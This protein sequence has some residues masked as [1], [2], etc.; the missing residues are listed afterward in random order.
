[1]NKK[2][3][4]PDWGPDWDFPPPGDIL[5]TDDIPLPL[6]EDGVIRV[7]VW[8]IGPDGQNL[9]KE[10][11]HLSKQILMHPHYANGLTGSIHVYVTSP[12]SNE[13]TTPDDA[14]NA[15]KPPVGQ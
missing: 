5:E 3:L 10:Q 2:I 1:M 11:S 4:P 8:F 14:E 7:E 6:A 15:A 12:R 13:P 9:P